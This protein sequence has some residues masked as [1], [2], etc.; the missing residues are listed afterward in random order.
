LTKLWN[1]VINL[2]EPPPFELHH[3]SR[4]HRPPCIAS[5]F[6]AWSSLLT[7]DLMEP[8]GSRDWIFSIQNFFN[9]DW[10]VFVIDF[11]NN[12][13]EKSSIFYWKKEII[14][15]RFFNWKNQ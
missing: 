13:F 3:M 10:N 2:L 5:I 7:L 15:V 6:E 11:F 1:L 8:W 14:I 4:S 9:P 12:I